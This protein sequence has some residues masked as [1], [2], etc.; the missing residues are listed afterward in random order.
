MTVSGW[1]LAV[2]RL[3]RQRLAVG[4]RL[5]LERA[6]LDDDLTALRRPAAALGV[7]EVEALVVE[8][9]DGRQEH[10]AVAA[11]RGLQADGHAAAALGVRDPAHPAHGVDQRLVDGCREERRRG[12]LAARVGLGQVAL[13]HRVGAGDGAHGEDADGDRQHDQD[14]AHRVAAQ[15]PQHLAPADATHRRPPMLRSNAASLAAAVGQRRRRCVGRRACSG[16]RGGIRIERAVEDPAVRHVHDA[17]RSLRQ[18]GVVGHGH[19]RPALLH[20]GLEE[21]EDD[22][23]R[24]RVEVARRLVGDEQ[25]RVVGQRTGDR[26]ALLLPTG[27]ARRQLACLI[28][29]AHALEQAH[30]PLV[31]LARRPQPAEVHRQHHVLDHGQRRQQL[32]ELEDDADRPAAPDG[33]PALGQEAQ[34]LAGNGHHPG[35]R[36]VDAGDHVHERRLAAARPTDDADELAGVDLEI[37][38]IEGAERPGVGDVVLDDRAQVDE[39]RAGRAPACH[40]RSR[41]ARSSVGKSRRLLC[42]R[43]FEGPMSRSL[44]SSE[45]TSRVGDRFST[46]LRRARGA[47]R[48]A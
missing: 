42:A 5:E 13:Q 17:A 7:D 3:D 15:V 40:R 19:D 11:I 25:G 38:A 21:L 44:P 37:D 8:V 10:L 43:P 32:E 29:H 45:S 9:G 33:G 34:V 46:R 31:S 41:S 36:A 12:G 1:R 18:L 48:R 30:G 20:E 26:D 2:G 28:G 27:G 39:V 4:Q 14:G 24:R 23:R 16:V 22:I 35:R 6:A 47:C